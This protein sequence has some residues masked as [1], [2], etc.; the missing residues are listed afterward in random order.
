VQVSSADVARVRERQ[1]ELGVPESFEWV[2]DLT[3][4]PTQA[5]GKAGLTVRLCP[6]LVLDGAELLAL[7]PAPPSGVVT[8]V[9]DAESPALAA[10]RRW[11]RSRSLRAATAWGRRG[12]AARDAV[13]ASAA[14][15]QLN[16]LRSQLR[17][18]ATVRV[19]GSLPGSRS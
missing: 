10:A 11:R 7:S 14:P 3:P 13:A 12:S 2:H 18:G 15:S 5:A 9:L 1:R 8:E 4:S 17:D 6:L 19:L 16:G